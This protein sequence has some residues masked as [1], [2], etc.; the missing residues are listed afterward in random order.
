MERIFLF[1]SILI[2]N[3]CMADKAEQ[4]EAVLLNGMQLPQKWALVSMS[5]MIAD[6]LPSTGA[7]MQ[8]QEFYL[9]KADGTF[10]KSRTEGD[11][12]S[13]ATGT[14]EIEELSDGNYLQLTYGASNELIGNCTGEP[15]ELL[16]F[17]SE[18]TL[19]GTWWAC[20]GPGL[21]YERS[22]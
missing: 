8:W 5:G 16:R 19:S 21:I 14:Y 17:E 6:V 18:N 9:L 10:T 7:D 22:E 13:E 20:D 4:E 2:I 1:L 12:V 11:A 15:K 3:G